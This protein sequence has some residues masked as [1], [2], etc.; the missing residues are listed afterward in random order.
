MAGDVVFVDVVFDIMFA[1]DIEFA[2]IDDDNGVDVDVVVDNE[3]DAVDV[4]EELIFR[5]VEL[6]VVFADIDDDNGVDVD[7][8]VDNE[9]DEV[10]ED[11]VL[12]AV[13]LVM[14][15]VLFIEL[16]IWNIG[17]E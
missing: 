7:V 8:V 6:D 15:F 17:S 12:N 13:L 1:D 3:V 4:I 11:S 2:D 14:L 10:L 5:D 16:G 9:V